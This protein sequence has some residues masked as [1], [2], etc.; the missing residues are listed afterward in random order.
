MTMRNLEH[1][2]RPRSIA[3]IG[4]DRRRRSLLTDLGVAGQRSSCA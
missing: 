4:P 1:L 3:L 2:L